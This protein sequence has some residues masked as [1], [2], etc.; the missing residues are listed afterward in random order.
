MK[1]LIA[2]KTLTLIVVLAAAVVP[3]CLFA[4]ENVSDSDALALIRSTYVS[5]RQ[6]F[7][8][9]NMQLTDKENKTFWPLY[10]EYRLA[11]ESL[12]DELVK[13]VL[14]YA[15]AYP[16]MPEDRSRE[17]LKKLCNLEQ[18]LAK[19]RAIYLAKFGKVLPASKTLRFAQLENRMDIALRLQLAANVPLVPTEG[20]LSATTETTSGFVQGFPGGTF[21]QTRELVATVTAVDK[22]A[23]KVTLLSADG[24][25]ETV[26]V[27]PEVANFNQVQI[28]DRLKIVATEELVVNM[29]EPGDSANTGSAGLVALA[30][31]GAKPGG[32]LAE[33]TWL[34]ATV[35]GVDARSHTAT[36]KFEDGS[37]RT[38]RVRGDVDLNESRIG[39]KVV[40][41]ATEMVAISVEKP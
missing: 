20:R 3:S 22:G 11:K 40:F 41:S 33:T 13:L 5:D 6:A 34:T 31:K 39:R 37:T 35:T 15:D 26:R 12:G 27:R 18:K 29:V 1:H 10:R 7:V 38:L 9:A 30:P 19:E 21:V 8:A 4:A 16:N 24:I 23:R 28:G 32:V 17:L 36:L 14:E 2:L 25:R